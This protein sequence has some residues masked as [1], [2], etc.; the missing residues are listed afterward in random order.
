M[1]SCGHPPCPRL[2]C[3]NPTPKGGMRHQ[4]HLASYDNSTFS[5]AGTAGAL[6][7][8]F[9]IVP[10]K[11]HISPQKKVFPCFCWL[12]T[13]CG[14][15]ISRKYHKNI[16]G[17]FVFFRSGGSWQFSVGSFQLA[18]FSWQ[19]SVGSLRVGQ[20]ECFYGVSFWQLCTP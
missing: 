7:I 5:F 10:P 1:F 11:Y 4:G 20:E 18:V 14:E 15:I 19:F 12:S 3:T 16:T 17:F 9:F 6:H 2:F 8:V 13:D